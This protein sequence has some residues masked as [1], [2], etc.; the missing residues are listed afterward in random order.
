MYDEDRIYHFIIHKYQFPRKI[1]Q[2]WK[3]AGLY[4]P[5]CINTFIFVRLVSGEVLR[6]WKKL[7]PNLEDA[8]NYLAGWSI[9]VLD[10]LLLSFSP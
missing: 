6:F 5:I 3:E 9:F 2:F 1:N 7:L 4:G 10:L 8:L